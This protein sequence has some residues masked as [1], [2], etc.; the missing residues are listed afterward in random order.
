LGAEKNQIAIARKM[1]MRNT[2][3]IIRPPSII[4]KYKPVAIPTSG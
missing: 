4:T 2:I 1:I 3:A